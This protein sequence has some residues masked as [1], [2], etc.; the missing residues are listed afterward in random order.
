MVCLHYLF[1]IA[2]K[3]VLIYMF[4]GVWYKRLNI[5]SEYGDSQH[6]VLMLK[7]ADDY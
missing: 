2:G 6:K 1:S 3:Y 7:S 4:M 5:S